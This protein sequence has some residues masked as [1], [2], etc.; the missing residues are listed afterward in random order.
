MT[1]TR[2]AAGNYESA[3]RFSTATEWL[4]MIAFALGLLP[5]LFLLAIF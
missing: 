5:S 2:Y 3:R 1:T 4:I